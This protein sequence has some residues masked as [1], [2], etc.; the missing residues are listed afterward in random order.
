MEKKDLLG[1]TTRGSEREPD[2]IPSAMAWSAAGFLQMTLW[3][4]DSGGGS[5]AAL[6][7]LDLPEIIFSV[8]DSKDPGCGG[9]AT[10]WQPWP[11]DLV[12][13]LLL[14]LIFATDE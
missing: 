2:A 7:L 5:L 3:S 10:R 1:R 8:F 11:S 9:L 6:A 12:D 13:P 4:F 14:V